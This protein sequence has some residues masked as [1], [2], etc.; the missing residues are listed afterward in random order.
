[1]HVYIYIYIERER[2]RERERARARI[3]TPDAAQWSGVSPS[4]FFVLTGKSLLMSHLRMSLCPLTAAQLHM[5]V[6]VC[7]CVCM[8]HC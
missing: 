4:L 8:H 6:C 7:V 1:M 3:H 2:E 5:Y